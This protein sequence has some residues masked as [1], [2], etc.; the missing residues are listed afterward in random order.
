MLLLAEVRTLK[1]GGSYLRSINMADQTHDIRDLF[2]CHEAS[3]LA[4]SDYIA[5]DIVLVRSHYRS[6]V[7]AY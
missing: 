3:S 6:L 2:R 5:G 1:G 4:L 7:Q